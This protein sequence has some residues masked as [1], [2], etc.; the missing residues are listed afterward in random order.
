MEQS[1]I[2][3]RQIELVRMMMVPSFNQ[4]IIVSKPRPPLLDVQTGWSPHPS[5]PLFSLFWS[6]MLWTLLAIFL[7]ALCIAK[8]ISP[9]NWPAK[10]AWK[11]CHDFSGCS[12]LVEER[13]GH[14]ECS[15]AKP[16]TVISHQPCQAGQHAPALVERSL[17]VPLRD[18][19]LMLYLHFFAAIH[20]L[21]HTG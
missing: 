11:R 17:R 10:S 20:S 4:I 21:D 16:G 7:L 13:V 1:T 12:P 14:D 9:S 2:F 19:M 15:A 18:E 8:R 5:S 3:T 6:M